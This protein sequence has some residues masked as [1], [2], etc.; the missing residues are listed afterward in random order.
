MFFTSCVV[1]SVIFKTVELVSWKSIRNPT[2]LTGW[3]DILKI[4]KTVVQFEFICLQLAI[5][6]AQKFSFSLYCTLH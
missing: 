1:G 3:Y 2:H 5:K 6:K 4:Y